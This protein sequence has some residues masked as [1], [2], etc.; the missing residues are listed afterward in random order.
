MKYTPLDELL[1][2]P[3]VKILRIL[4]RCDWFDSFDLYEACGAGA[5]TEGY[6]KFQSAVQDAVTCGDVDR[7]A[8]LKGKLTQGKT[9]AL[10]QYRVTAQGRAKLARLLAASTP[11]A[12]EFEDDSL[13][14]IANAATGE[15][16]DP[17]GRPILDLTGQVFGRLTVLNRTRIA[18]QTRWDCQC[19]CGA[20]TSKRA[21]H[22]RDGGT[23]SCGCLRAEESSARRVRMHGGAPQLV[24]A[25]SGSQGRGELSPDPQIEGGGA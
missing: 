12:R 4:N 15:R 25:A 19:S 20:V 5:G 11:S 17:R 7:R 9:G 10:C 16:P 2:R 1:A 6:G 18:G 8:F 13:T 14:S 22:L 21:D 23:R 24:Q 3:R